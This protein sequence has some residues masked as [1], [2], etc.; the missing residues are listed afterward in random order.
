M[1]IVFGASLFPQPPYAII[2]H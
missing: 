1:R 2:I